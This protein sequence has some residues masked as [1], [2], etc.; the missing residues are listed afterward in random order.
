M[1]A[2]PM[3]GVPKQIKFECS[4]SMQSEEVNRAFCC[5]PT[6]RHLTKITHSF[7]CLHQAT[8][9]ALDITLWMTKCLGGWVRSVASEAPFRP[10]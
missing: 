3:S 8:P 4:F 5:L 9:Q 6:V 2:Q 10:S 7:S 1:L